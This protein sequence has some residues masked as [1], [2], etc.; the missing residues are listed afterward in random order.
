MSA[1]LL[2]YT[3]YFGPYIL[4]VLSL[5]TFLHRKMLLFGVISGF[6]VNQYLNAD[7]KR[8]YR[9]PRPSQR[10]HYIATDFTEKVI[11]A[12]TLGVQEYGMPS[13]HSQN[14]WFFTS[15]MYFSLKSLPLTALFATISCLT[16][17]QRVLYK[18]HTIKQVLMG[19]MVGGLFG[20]GWHYI[21]TNSLPYILPSS[22]F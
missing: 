6:F 8:L 1:S 20:Y 16:G 3:G 18:N 22:F 5:F 19:A 17:I 9:E 15:F 13:G 4:A 10:Y 14:V 2:L 21:I 12:S 11:S 7:L